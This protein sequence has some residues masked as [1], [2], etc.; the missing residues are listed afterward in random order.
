MGERKSDVKLSMCKK[1][2]REY[3]PEFTALLVVRFGQLLAVDA[4]S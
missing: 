4:S 1:C 3:E 2:F